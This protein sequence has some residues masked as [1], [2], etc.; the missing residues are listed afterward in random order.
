MHRSQ[1]K[2]N[3]NNYIKC[4]LLYCMVRGRYDNVCVC[5]ASTAVYTVCTCNKLPWRCWHENLLKL[6]L[7]ASLCDSLASGYLSSKGD[8][9]E[10]TMR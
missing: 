5:A 1:G 10:D 6:V 2:G 7:T 3:K 8:R 4:K 9:H